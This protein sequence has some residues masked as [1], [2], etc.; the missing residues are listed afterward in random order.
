MNVRKIQLLVPTLY[1][2][3]MMH[4]V[5]VFSDHNPKCE[6]QTDN[7]EIVIDKKRP[8]FQKKKFN[9]NLIG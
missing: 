6:T 1:S 2:L 4:T 8:K 3:L 5:K 7:W 9:E